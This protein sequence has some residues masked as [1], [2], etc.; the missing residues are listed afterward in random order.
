MAEAR[1]SPVQAG[2]ARLYHYEKFNAEWLEKTLR[3]QKIRCSDPSSLNDPWDCRPWFDYR[4]MAE[5]PAKLE[6]MLDNFRNTDFAD[7]PA[8]PKF[9]DRIRNNPDELRK[10]LGGLS[11]SF[12]R[13]ICKRRIYCLT[14]DAC[15]VLMWSHYAENHRGIC[16]E[17]H[18]GNGLFLRA[19][20]VIY[21]SAY[22]IWVPQEMR[23]T[24]DQAILTKS[25]DWEYEQEWRLIGSP[26]YPEGDPLKPEG[27]Y[28]RL[29]PRALKAV[30][31]GCEADYEAVERVVHQHAPGV[32][33]RCVSR[34]PN[35][36]RL[37]IVTP[38]QDPAVLPS[39]ASEHALRQP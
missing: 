29:P 13:E 34:V 26:E 4:P 19:R 37:E 38:P 2:L 24:A 32:P 30:I 33:V 3:D 1:C 22:P 27:D 25:K 8:R 31:A 21:C 17:F 9:E 15:S 14:P 39:V 5:D 36:Y 10:F 23:A 6:A 28:L 12:Q 11:Q 16:L 18:L 7:Q 20:K 35:H